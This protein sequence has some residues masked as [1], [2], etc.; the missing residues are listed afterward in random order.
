MSDL[1][2]FAKDEDRTVALERALINAQ[3]EL[4]KVKRSKEQYADVL[5]RAAGD[6]FSAFKVQPVAAPKAAKSRSKQQ[7]IA[8]PLLSDT[9]LGKVTAHG[10]VIEYTTE[11]AVERVGLFAD[12]I[13]ELT[14]IQRTH[15]P[16][17]EIHVAVLGDI[18]EGYDIFPG[19]IHLLDS[20][21]YR[22][23]VVST[24]MLADYARK[25]AANFQSVTMTCVIGNHGRI[26]RRG[27]ADPETNID[28][29]VY[30]MAEMAT[31]GEPRIKWVIPQGAYDRNW[32][33]VMQVGAYRALCIH[34][35]Q[36]RGHS[37]LPWY[38]F[39]KKINSWAAGAIPE[40][41]GDVFMGHWH[42]RA[43]IPLNNRNVYVN[44]STEN[45]N[46]FAQEMLA[47]MSEPSQWLLYVHPEDGRVTT[48]Y[49]VDL[50]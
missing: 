45:Y 16:V 3:R 20:G 25:L 43:L 13:I 50:R 18:V 42:Q 23:V 48:S 27:D 10:D 30:T 9:Q 12:K 31:A 7:E 21:L 4:D 36:I 41:F 8:V 26:G 35:D 49:G 15:H 17:D 2:Q 38:G 33:S 44:G 24:S 11:K 47:A 6:A 37:G 46:T 32:Y 19:Q 29:M 34:G 5:Y 1:E 39:Q 22:Q 28:R 14:E 40:S